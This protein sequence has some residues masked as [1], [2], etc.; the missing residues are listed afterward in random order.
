VAPGKTTTIYIK[1]EDRVAQLKSHQKKIER[2]MVGVTLLIF[3][4][5]AAFILIPSQ[6]LD[7]TSAWISRFE[8]GGT[9]SRNAATNCLDPRNRKT[10]YCL[11]RAAVVE[12]DWK[13]MSRFSGGKANQFTLTGR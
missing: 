5:I 10:A 4:G 3:G 1:P 12:S 8:N 11:D 2:M 13:A 7:T 9:V 6:A